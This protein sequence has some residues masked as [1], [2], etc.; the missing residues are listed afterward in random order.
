M[1]WKKEIFFSV[2]LLIFNWIIYTVFSLE[3]TT[4]MYYAARL[5]AYY[6]FTLKIVQIYFAQSSY[7]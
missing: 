7:S 4:E 5:I 2:I 6:A 3:M 1:F